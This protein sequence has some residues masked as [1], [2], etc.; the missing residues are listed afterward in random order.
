MGIQA[1]FSISTD[2][3]NDV[4]LLNKI[5]TFSGNTQQDISLIKTDNNLSHSCILDSFPVI[6]T[7]NNYTITTGHDGTISH[8]NWINSTNPIPTNNLNYVEEFFNLDVNVGQDLVIC[9]H[10]SI[11]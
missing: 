10:D 9:N 4:L 8:T 11:Y 6:T 2:L 7:A 1:G 5:P 3:I